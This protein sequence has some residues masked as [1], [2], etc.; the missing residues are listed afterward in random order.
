MERSQVFP[1]KDE[2]ILD[3]LLILSC[4]EDHAIC[5][6]FLQKGIHL[7]SIFF[8]YKTNTRVVVNDILYH[9][10]LQEQQFTVRSS[11]LQ[12]GI[13]IQKLEYERLVLV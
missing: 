3:D 9:L 13:V 2:K 5:R 1:A 8:F 12:N 10:F 6:P 11:S 7:S 4:E